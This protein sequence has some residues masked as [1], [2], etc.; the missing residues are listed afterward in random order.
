MAIIT[1]GKL[2]KADFEK[3]MLVSDSNVT[4][5]SRPTISVLPTSAALRDSRST[6]S[7]I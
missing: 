1:C 7:K 3:I 6:W 5:S 2:A 4:V